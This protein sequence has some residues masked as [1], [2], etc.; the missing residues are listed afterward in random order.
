MSKHGW[1]KIYPRH[2][3]KIKAEK[4]VRLAKKEPGGGLDNYM[5]R[6]VKKKRGSG[7]LYQVYYKP[8]QRSKEKMSKNRKN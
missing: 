3:K 2:K 4:Y 6:K 5:I 8:K 1:N 7:Y